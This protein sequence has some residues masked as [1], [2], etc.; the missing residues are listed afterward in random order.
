MPP[1]GR[2]DPAIYI[3]TQMMSGSLLSGLGILAL[4]VVPGC[5]GNADSAKFRSPAGKF[6]VSFL[7]L[8]KPPAAES[9]AVGESHAV[10]YEVLFHGR[11]GKNPVRAAFADVY[12][13][14]Q[15]DK[16]TPQADIFARILWSPMEDFAILPEENWERAPGPPARKA[17]DLKPGGAW[18]EAELRFETHQWISRYKIAGEFKEGCEHSVVA[19]DGRKGKTVVIREGKEKLAYAIREFKKPLL[20]LEKLLGECPDSLA[21]AQFREGCVRYNVMTG[22]SAAIPCPKR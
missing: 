7:P 16:P 3:D 21:Q 5:A 11:D 19:F 4:A 10:K 6:S 1:N 17:V 12:G 9:A 20:F 14:S 18:K 2:E 22:K 8:P 15:D 13:F